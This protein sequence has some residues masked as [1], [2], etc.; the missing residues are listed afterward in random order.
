MNIGRRA[1]ALLGIAPV[2]AAPGHEGTL[3]APS[4]LA[5]DEGSASQET[6][7][8]LETSYRNLERAI[9]YVGHADNKVL[10]ALAFQGGFLAEV[11]NVS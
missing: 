4:R 11:G 5:A 10:I 9:D 3:N 7:I 2:D 1:R 6:E 8:R